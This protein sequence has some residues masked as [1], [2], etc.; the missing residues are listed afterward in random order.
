MIFTQTDAAVAGCFLFESH[1]ATVGGTA[2]S[3]PFTQNV[4]GEVVGEEHAL[5]SCIVPAGTVWNAGNLTTRLDVTTGEAGLTLVLVSARRYNA[6][7]GSFEV[8]GSLTTLE[9]MAATG[10]RVHTFNINA[11]S[12]PVSGDKLV[13]IY[14]FDNPSVDTLGFSYRPNQNIDT[15][16][17]LP[18][19]GGSWL[20]FL[21]RRRSR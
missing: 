14:G 11:A 17:M 3:T 13:I 15:P 5:F 8:L 10:V 21:R 19:V 16:L 4:N 1:D 20:P 9:G 6:V 2:G 12:A 7:C 18:S